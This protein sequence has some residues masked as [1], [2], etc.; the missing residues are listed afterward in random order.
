MTDID[1]DSF[2]AAP[3]I[4]IM[5]DLDIFSGGNEKAKASSSH[6]PKISEIEADVRGKEGPRSPSIVSKV[7]NFLGFQ[8]DVDPLPSNLIS[9]IDNVRSGT[10][11]VQSNKPEEYPKFNSS[12]ARVSVPTVKAATT[13]KSFSKRHL[14]E[15]I[16]FYIRKLNELRDTKTTSDITA[17]SSIDE[18]RAEYEELRD[19]Y[20]MAS[21]I[22]GYETT[23]VE[24]AAYLE[25][26][27][28]IVDLPI[29]TDGLESA[30]SLSMRD[31]GEK[32]EQIYEE[33][34]SVK[35]NPILSV[36]MTILSTIIK[37]HLL[38]SAMNSF[39]P[40]VADDPEI[41]EIITRR[42]NEMGSKYANTSLPEMVNH[43]STPAMPN[44]ERA[45]QFNSGLLNEFNRL[46][47]QVRNGGTSPSKSGP[48]PPIHTKITK[49]PATEETAAQIKKL[50]ATLLAPEEE[51]PPPRASMKGPSAT[52]NMS[53]FLESI[54]VSPEP[55]ANE[56]GRGNPPDANSSRPPALAPVAEKKKS[57]GRKAANT[58]TVS[59]DI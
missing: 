38:Q 47:S 34:G 59:I 58:A 24:G 14:L 33:Y 9:D 22:N 39:G 54:K 7:T 25:S 10:P 26:F 32:F 28:S 37:T 31:C 6:I 35:I 56:G 53:N 43:L 46:E 12:T 36:S 13:R 40:S 45:A 2:S 15:K 19:E 48:P 8:T 49:P 11:R 57:R 1:I 20:H 18:I 44:S 29:N 16:G 4:N 55:P 5:E 42:A 23:I 41:N 21:T 52:V 51:T 17:H 30:I 27:G 3:K 50:G